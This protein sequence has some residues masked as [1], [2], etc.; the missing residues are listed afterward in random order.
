[1][2]NFERRCICCGET[3][4]DRGNKDSLCQKCD[5]NYWNQSKY[6][7]NFE[8]SSTKS[9]WDWKPTETYF[10]KVRKEVR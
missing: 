6:G 2:S 8:E 5:G 3:Y 10:K 1:M 9:L 4:Y 7:F